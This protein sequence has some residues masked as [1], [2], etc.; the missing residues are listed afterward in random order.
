[1]LY[2]KINEFCKIRNVAGAY[3]NGDKPT[4][5]V[6]YLTSLI[7]SQGIEY[8]LD[9]FKNKP[10]SKFEALFTGGEDNNNYFNIY[11]K[12]SSDKMFIAHHDI[13]NPKTDN[14][15]DNSASIINC[16][17]L[18]KLHPEV[19]IAIIDG[20]E[21]PSMGIGSNRLGFKICEG[22]FG[23]IS[24]VLNLELTGVG[25]QNFFVGNYKGPLLN[26]IVKLFNPPMIQPPFNDSVILR[27]YGI[28]STVVT[29]LPLE[30]DG[31]LNMEFLYHCH[32]SKDTLES[33]NTKDMK[34]FTENIVV[35]L[36]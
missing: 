23:K 6:N 26:K 35:K 2:E 7:E 4:N 33:I 8:E 25:G 13:C 17:S 18:K 10:K 5:R 36:L 19:N 27:R 30:E 1:M 14:A 12:G 16:L 31:G 28:D 32:T 34:D 22:H 9:V 15:N 20:E 21:P 11:L 3:K 29:T 24:W